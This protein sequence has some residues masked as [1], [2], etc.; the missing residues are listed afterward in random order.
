MVLVVGNITISLISWSAIMQTVSIPIMEG[1]L[2]TRHGV[3]GMG[4]GWGQHRGSPLQCFVWL[5]MEHYWMDSSYLSSYEARCSNLSSEHRFSSLW[6][7]QHLDDH[8]TRLVC[9]LSSFSSPSSMTLLEF[10]LYIWPQMLVLPFVIE[11]WLACFDCLVCGLYDIVVSTTFFSPCPCSTSTTNIMLPLLL[12]L[13][14]PLT[15]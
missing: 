5:H 9:E 13:L 1:N 15:P 12:L 2:V 11:H 14:S 10:L 7:G 8:D 6:N 3:E 4:R